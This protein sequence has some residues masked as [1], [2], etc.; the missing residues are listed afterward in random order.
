MVVNRLK[1][2][3][4]LAV[5]T[6]TFS[7]YLFA[8]TTGDFQYPPE[9]VIE[10]AQK[11][12]PYYV[13]MSKSELLKVYPISYMTSSYSEGD[14]EWILFNDIMTDNDDKDVIAF[15]LKDN[16]VAGWKKKEVEKTPAERLKAVEARRNKY[17][18]QSM[19][20]DGTREEKSRR[21]IYRPPRFNI[22]YY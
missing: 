15:Y 12:Q 2:V 19:D 7:S 18:A 13:G 6:V 21:P 4:F 3:F 17:G 11:D 22:Y 5:L 16:V 9:N 1:P 14:Q 10:A 20:M 8:E